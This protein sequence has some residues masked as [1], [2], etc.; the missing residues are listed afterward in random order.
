MAEG[1]RK[2]APTFADSGCSKLHVATGFI[3]DGLEI[4]GQ[5]GLAQG[6]ELDCTHRPKSSRERIPS[7]AEPSGDISPGLVVLELGIEKTRTCK[8]LEEWKKQNWIG[9]TNVGFKSRVDPFEGGQLDTDNDE[10]GNGE[11]RDTDTDTDDDDGDNETG[12]SSESHSSARHEQ[13]ILSS[14]RTRRRR[15]PRLTAIA[16]DALL[17]VKSVSHPLSST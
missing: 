6:G 3:Q 10:G 1:Q 11:S 5:S 16:L 2:G 13:S 9:K 17:V 14:H 12:A 7:T 15:C 8:T 4:C